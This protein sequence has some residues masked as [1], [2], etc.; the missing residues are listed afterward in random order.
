MEDFLNRIDPL[1]IPEATR[2]MVSGMARLL[3][4]FSQL[5][6]PVRTGNLRRAGFSQIEDDGQ[7]AIVAYGVSYAGVVEGG[8]QAHEIAARNARTLAFVPTSFNS[9]AGAERSVNAR[10]ASGAL[11]TGESQNP[12]VAVF[13]TH[14]FHPGTL[15]NPFM[16]QGWDDAEDDVATMISE[17]GQHWMRG[18]EQTEGV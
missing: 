13:P 12:G 15:A 10:R 11:T 9:L 3:L 18:E 16:I 4:R 1:R 14:V 2:A 17:V 5:D 8:S 6:S 7:S